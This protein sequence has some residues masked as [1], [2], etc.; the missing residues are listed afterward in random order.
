MDPDSPIQQTTDFP[1][2]M[3]KPGDLAELTIETVAFGGD[4]VGRHAGRVVF[5]PYTVDGDE[6]LVLV[7][8]VKKNYARGRLVKLHRSSPR[9]VE[10]ICRHY[11]L[12]GGCSYQHIA[13]DH[14]LHLKGRQVTEIME[15]IGKLP[16]PNVYSPVASPQ[17]F[18]YRCKADFHLEYPE[19]KAVVGFMNNENRGIVPIERCEIVEEGINMA[20]AAL[21]EKLAGARHFPVG[22]YPLWSL[23]KEALNPLRPPRTIIRYV[24]HHAVEVPYTG[25]FQANTAL[26]PHLID[27][28]LKAC[29]P[30][31]RETVVDAHC[32]SGLFSLFLSPHVGE[33][34]G[35]DWDAEAIA[36]ARQNARRFKLRNTFFHTGDAGEVIRREFY[37]NKK[38]ID[39]LI[40]DPPR[41][42]CKVSLLELV[43]EIQP[44]KVVYISCHPA[45]QAR[46]LARLTAQGYEMEY[47]TPFDMF[48]QTAHVETVAVL[49][50]K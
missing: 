35:V 48:P 3:V 15:R 41:T 38:K 32:G 11:G 43:T 39:L 14:Q 46:D 17:H 30:T 49:T 22:R 25:F 10:P 16:Q 21:Y 29:A 6:A 34:W 19:G 26:L 40:L 44:P 20:L 12:C 50:P 5:V 24:G 7:K 2:E 23:E 1:G 31:G 37:N 45:T 9:R 18:Y 36:C 4:G 8:A 33:V 13:Y 47:V 27:H 28:V 42:G